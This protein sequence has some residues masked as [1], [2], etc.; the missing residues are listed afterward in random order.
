MIATDFDLRRLKHNDARLTSLFLNFSCKRRFGLDDVKMKELDEFLVYNTT[1]EEV[2][3]SIDNS[4]GSSSSF[5]TSETTTTI[6]QDLSADFESILRNVGRLPKLKKLHFSSTPNGPGVVPVQA[7]SWIL[8]SHTNNNNNLLETLIVYDLQLMGTIGEFFDLATQVQR[9]WYLRRFSMDEIT[10]RLLGSE[11]T[12]GEDRPNDASAPS[13]TTTDAAL[14]SLLFSCAMLPSLQTV[15]LSAKNQNAKSTS[16]ASATTSTVTDNNHNKTTTATK[17]SLSVSAVS[18]LFF[19]ASIQVLHLKHWHWTNEQLQ[20]IAPLLGQNRQLQLLSWGPLN[21]H[22][23][24]PAACRA[25]CTCLEANHQIQH[26]ELL[27]SHRHLAD[28]VALPLAQALTH[29]RGLKSVVLTSTAP[30]EPASRKRKTARSRQLQQ[31]QQPLTVKAQ[32]AFVAMAESNY[33]LKNIQLFTNHKQRKRRSTAAAKANKA[34]AAAAANKTTTIKR[35][36]N[37]RKSPAFTAPEPIEPTLA[38][39]TRLN[40]MGRQQLLALDAPEI[41]CGALGNSLVNQDLD[42]IYYFLHRNPTLCVHAAAAKKKKQKKDHPEDEC[43]EPVQKKRRMSTTTPM[44][45]RV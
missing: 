2:V 33:M 42:A 20:A 9:L 1:I 23:L 25:V 39:Y 31:Q 36:T 14:D 7:L 3:M 29:N 43:R 12:S 40:R 21:C 11:T 44:E 37:S 26:L 32:Q 16:A 13:Y 18:A 6:S 5:T 15:T 27:W 34:R 19:S 28:R 41:W 24:S 35:K 38:L 22:D 4:F 17:Q 10:T 8:E 45:L 30:P